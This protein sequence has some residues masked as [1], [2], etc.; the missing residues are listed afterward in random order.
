MPISSVYN[1]LSTIDKNKGPA[2]S[3]RFI[4]EF[5][6]P[7][8]LD[9]AS[10]VRDLSYQC[11]TSELPGTTLVTGEYRTYGPARK[12]ATLTGYNDITFGIYCTNEFWEKPLFDSWIDYINPKSLGWDFRY[13]D[14]YTTSITVTQFDLNENMA[15]KVVLNKA[16]PFNVAPLSLTWSGSNFHILQVTFAYDNYAPMFI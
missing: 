9:F 10:K 2:M 4:V 16:F 14:D 5:T 11:E 15:Y 8:Q 7:S 6:L 3:D 13:K 12:F 1:F